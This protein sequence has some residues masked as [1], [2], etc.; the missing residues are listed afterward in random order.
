MNERFCPGSSCQ[1]R[2]LAGA[3]TIPVAPRLPHGE[4]AGFGQQSSAAE[5]LGEEKKKKEESFFVSE[6][7]ALNRIPLSEVFCLVLS[8]SAQRRRW[9]MP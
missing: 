3:Q 8:T 1:I 4:A 7:L 6:G 2:A 5:T 9:L